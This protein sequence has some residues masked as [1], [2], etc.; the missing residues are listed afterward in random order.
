MAQTQTKPK[1][2]PKS[3]Q[4]KAPAY[5]GADP[6]IGMIM[7]ASQSPAFR[8]RSMGEILA[9][10]RLFY[11]MSGMQ[12]QSPKQMMGDS[13]GYV[14]AHINPLME[15]MGRQFQRQMQVGNR[16]IQGATLAY[17]DR[18]APYSGELSGLYG[19]MKG[20]NRAE[21]GALSGY[22]RGRGNELAGGLTSDLAA[23]NHPDAQG[24]GAVPGALGE[25][26]GGVMQAMGDIALA[27]LGA[28]EAAD[29]GYVDKLSQNAPLHGLYNQRI[30][31]NRLADA[32]SE[33]MGNLMST[34]PGMIADQYQRMLDRDMQMIGLQGQNRQGMA[35]F[36]TGNWDRNMQAELARLGL[37][38]SAAQMGSD[39]GQFVAGEQ[40][41][42]YRAQLGE[43]G[44][45]NRAAM[46][47]QG[48]LSEQSGELFAKAMNAAS[49]L[50]ADS[51]SGVER[52]DWSGPTFNKR[53]DRLATTIMGMD[54]ALG[55]PAAK[56]LALQVLYS[57]GITRRKPK[58][59]GRGPVQPPSDAA[60]RGGGL[61][62]GDVY[63]GTARTWLDA[64]LGGLP[65]WLG[66]LV[67]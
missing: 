31:N 20:M 66:G 41:Q 4:P 21:T 7:Q 5:G 12:R 29:V 53:L 28:N 27:R 61:G 58:Q 42:N 49:T 3:S 23:I 59:P 6:Y 33:Q 38:Q 25:N 11:P 10:A 52:T 35:D 22:I 34:V 14:N 67:G 37:I 19:D 32:F 8:Q 30:L 26:A 2:K 43:W 48:D 9:L 45:T 56:G 63:G 1:T 60:E 16:G 57:L 15:N 39:W 13:V 44:A 17:M 18:L 40:G 65:S 55:R 47:A 64:Y 36:V 54:P 46:Q 24:M 51:F 50:F 62:L